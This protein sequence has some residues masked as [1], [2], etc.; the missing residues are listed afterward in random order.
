MSR[1][2]PLGNPTQ[3]TD[4]EFWARQ[5]HEHAVFLYLLIENNDLARRAKSIDV[6]FTNILPKLVGK[7][8]PEQ[9]KLLVLPIRE[10]RV[11]KTEVLNRLATGEWLGWAW[12][13]FVEHIRAELDYAWARMTTKILDPRDELCRWEW[14][15]SEHATF[16]SKLLDPT[17][18]S[19]TGQ[20]DTLASQF[21]T[22]GASCASDTMGTLLAMSRERG[23]ELDSYLTTLGAGAPN[24][25]SILHPVLAIHVVREG[26]RFLVTLD[27]LKET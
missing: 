5:L 4:V 11:L 27:R 2:P 23:T 12:P 8:V 14:F 19:K 24:L 16:A 17:E 9:V 7:S 13:K 21:A 20:A 1:L 26:R 15:M 10:L 18:V 25:R 6:E 22:L 3:E